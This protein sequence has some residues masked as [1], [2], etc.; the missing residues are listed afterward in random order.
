MHLLHNNVICAVHV[1][2]CRWLRCLFFDHSVCCLSHSGAFPGQLP[3]HATAAEDLQEAGCKPGRVSPQCSQQG[4]SVKVVRWWCAASVRCFISFGHAPRFLPS[5]AK[6]ALDKA[7]EEVGIVPISPS[8]PSNQNTC[9][10]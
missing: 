10:S 2:I 3:V 1:Y 5:L 9:E 6:S 4:L 8:S 7:M